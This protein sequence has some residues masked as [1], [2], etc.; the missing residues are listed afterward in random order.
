M[1]THIIIQSVAW[2][3]I[4]PLGMVLGIVHSRLHVPVQ[5][6]GTA[7]AT[8]GYFLGHLHGGREYAANAHAQFA[9]WLMLLLI[10]QVVMGV[11]LKLHLEKGFLSTLR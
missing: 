2:G 3:A 6:L 10:V 8:V 11:Y 5:V 4:F 1:W 9:N 7:L